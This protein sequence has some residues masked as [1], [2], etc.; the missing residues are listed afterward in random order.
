MPLK[1]P[2]HSIT[3]EIETYDV[4]PDDVYKHIPTE[5]AELNALKQTHPKL[6]QSCMVEIQDTEKR[7]LYD[8]TVD[9]DNL[10]FSNDDDVNTT[11]AIRYSEYHDEPTMDEHMIQTLDDLTTRILTTCVRFGTTV[12]YKRSVT[13]D[14]CEGDAENVTR[15]IHITSDTVIYTEGQRKIYTQESK[16]TIAS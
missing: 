15:T 11:I 2:T 14:T 16:K 6:F 7:Y 13:H 5:L 4:H 9:N 10:P 12:F 3:Y 1:N 8:P